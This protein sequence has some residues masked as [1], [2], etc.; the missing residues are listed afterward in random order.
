LTLEFKRKI[1]SKTTLFE[2]HSRFSDL[3]RRR[4]IEKIRGFH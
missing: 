1:I 3:P 4:Y 2:T